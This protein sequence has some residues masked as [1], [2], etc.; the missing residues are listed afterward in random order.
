VIT[1]GDNAKFP[2]VSPHK[3]IFYD[4]KTST[5]ITYSRLRRDTL[6]LA[7][8]IHRRFGIPRT[9]DV[10]GAGSLAGPVVLVHLPNCI[11]W[12][13]LALG[14][15]AA[16]WTVTGT[17]PGYTA[18][19]LAHVVE[20]C[21]PRVIICNP[22]SG[23]ER[24]VRAACTAANHK[25]LDIVFVESDND[26]YGTPREALI[27]NSWT[28]LLSN[29]ELQVSPLVNYIL[30]GFEINAECFP[31]VCARSKPTGRIHYVDFWSVP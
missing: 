6:R 25:K 22:G 16:G 4:P 24:V 7:H 31:A 11:A 29:Q 13:V 27:K 26:I 12:P 9:T 10:F 15:L 19:E 2:P 17:N 1:A 21:E 14:F 28:S 8:G 20:Q 18:T 5:A 30:P 3:P 23:G